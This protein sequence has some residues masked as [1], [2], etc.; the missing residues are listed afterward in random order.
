M[1]R[2]S[3]SRFHALV[4][5]PGVVEVVLEAVGLVAPDGSPGGTGR[6]GAEHVEVQLG[7]M[8]DELEHPLDAGAVE[9]GVELIDVGRQVAAGVGG[10]D[11]RC[12]AVLLM[13]VEV[14]EYG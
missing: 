13:L 7:R 11:Q 8:V 5:P 6:Y 1:P 9:G 10:G 3:T 4:S 2:S 14:A 12:G